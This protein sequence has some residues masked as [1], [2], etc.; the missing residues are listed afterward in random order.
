MSQTP[1]DDLADALAVIAGRIERETSL[2]IDRA[3]ADLRR[4]DAEREL[5]LQNLER[6]VADRV[7]SV[8]DGAPGRD[9]D[10]DVVVRLV[11]EAVELRVAAIRV[12]QDGKSV[13]IDELRPVV[14][15]VVAAIP[16]AVDG[17]D[18]DPEVMRQ[19]V[20][21]AIAHAAAG[22]PAGRDG[23][24]AAPADIEREVNRAVAAAMGELD[25]PIGPAGKD[26]EPGSAGKDGAP[27]LLPIVKAWADDVHYA[28]AVLTH[29]G[30][31]YQATRD[32]AKEPPHGDWICIAAGGADGRDGRSIKIA[33]TYQEGADYRALDQV[34]LNG[35]SFTAKRD[36][37]GPCPGDGWQLSSAQGKRGNPGERGVKGERGEPG[38]AVIDMSID[39]EALFAI[40]NADGSKATCDLYPLLA[41]LQ[42]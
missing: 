15:E 13:T 1:L 18:A 37:P 31:T 7:A 32:T 4:V 21:E 29:N 20:D 3:L 33:G 27:G 34:T 11:N 16:K 9:A 14:E 28:G 19:M 40:R 38:P 39:G 22:I 12:P 17:K 8:K 41:R 6:A 36:N 5:R 25:L 26:G 42:R 30:S 2:R 10:P 24:D 23:K 35:A